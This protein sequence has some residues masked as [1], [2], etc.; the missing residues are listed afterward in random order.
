MR[1]HLL[2]GV[3]LFH[4]N[5]RDEAYEKLEVATKDLYEVKMNDTELST[6][7]EMGYEE[8]DARLALRSCAGQVD[9]A[10]QYIQE[11]SERISEERKNSAAE[12]QVNQEMIFA[13]QGGEWVNPRSIIRLMEMGYEGVWLWR[14]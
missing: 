12:R 13:G 1:L 11:R 7:V 5:R 3:L 8:S 4:Q 6:L 9:R 10:I 14:L 2:Q